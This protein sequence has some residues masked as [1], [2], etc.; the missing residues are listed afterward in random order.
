MPRRIV[1]YT[2]ID[3]YYSDQTHSYIALTWDD[4]DA[5]EMEQEAYMA[6]GHPMGLSAIYNT[7]II[8]EEE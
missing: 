4:V 2:S 1:K 5:M 7:E 3:P 6:Y 8:S